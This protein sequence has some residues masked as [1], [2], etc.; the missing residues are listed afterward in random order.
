MPAVGSD[1]SNDQIEALVTYTK[2]LVKRVSSG[3]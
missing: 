1:W 3:S 2:T